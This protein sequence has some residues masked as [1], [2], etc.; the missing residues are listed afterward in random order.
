MKRSRFWLAVASLIGAVSLFLGCASAPPPV[1]YRLDY[2]IEAQ[3]TEREPL[4]RTLA[5]QPVK[6]PETLARTNILYRV[7]PRI[8]QH[9]QSRF[10]EQSPS[11]ATQEQLVRTFEAAGVF[12][13]ITT[14][15][16]YLDADYTLDVSLTA[17]EEI[18]T[19]PDRAA[20]VAMRYELSSIRP[21]EVVLTGE[22]GSEVSISGGDKYRPEALAEAMSA[23]LR[24]CLDKMVVEVDKKVRER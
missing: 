5:I 2:K 20:L 14:R 4:D 3:P 19:V 10:W 17:F 21:R 15:R 24:E 12:K 9:Y 1:Y 16:L 13:R 18:R 7:S 8:L 22:A 23:A 6:A 11:Q